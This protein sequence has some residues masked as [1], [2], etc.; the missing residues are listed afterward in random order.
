MLEGRGKYF[1]V[2]ALMIV[3]LSVLTALFP[4]PVIRIAAAISGWMLFLM[5]VMYHH[6]DRFYLLCQRF[7][8]NIVNPDTLWSFTVRYDCA[9]DNGDFLKV[10]SVLVG[11]RYLEDVKMYDLTSSITEIKAKGISLQVVHDIDTLQIHILNMPVTYT[12]AKRT[13]GETI[14]PIIEEV[15][16]ALS[17]DDKHY[18]LTV[19]LEGIN[20]YFGLYVSKLKKQDIQGF[21]V[22]FNIDNNQ[23]EVTKN[24]IYVTTQSI[25]QMVEAARKC[26]LLGS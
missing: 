7:C 12:K 25:G 4:S 5:K 21:N 17:L 8:L 1:A 3:L 18:F 2:V 22:S 6:W 15:E 14:A 9:L 24:K 23:V 11:S 10:K 19:E 16:K 13:I 26:L 20:P